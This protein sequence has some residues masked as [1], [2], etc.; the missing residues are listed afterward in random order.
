M[1]GTSVNPRS[2]QLSRK[3]PWR[4]IALAG[5]ALMALAGLAPGASGEVSLYN[6]NFESPTILN[7]WTLTGDW[8]FKTNSACLPNELGYISPQTA[9]V[10]DFASECG[11]RNG[12]SGFATTKFDIE[13]PITLPAVRLQW[14]DYVEAEVGADFYF[15]QISTDG[16][17][18]WPFEVFRDSVNENFW[19]LESVD[20]T[21]FIGNSIRVRFGFSSDES[22]TGLGWYIDDLK[23]VGDELDPNVSAVAIEDA[24]VLEG[25]VGTT[26]MSFN[27]DIQP[28][29]ADPIIFER[30]TV[31]GTAIAGLDYVGTAGPV[32]IP[33]NTTSA[34]IVVDVLGDAFFESDETF[35]LNIFNPSDNAVITIGSAT[36]TIQ[37]DEVLTDKYVEDFEGNQ[38]GTF[39]WST[40]FLPD[41][42]PASALPGFP[43]LELWHIQS[44]SACLPG[45]VDGHTSPTR[46]LVFND[47]TNCNYDT[48]GAI[49]G[50][51]F[52]TS[53]QALHP[54]DVL[55]AEV[56]FQH[57]LE[58]TYN[59]GGATPPT[60]SLLIST[61]GN[62]FNP[63]AT[64]G[65]QEASAQN[66]RIPWRK[67][68]VDL[69]PYIGSSIQLAF[70]FTSPAQGA[71]ISGA[72]WYID[73]F[74]ISVS[75]RPAPVSKV[76]VQDAAVMEGNTGSTTLSFPVLVQ[77][78]NAQD[79]VLSF[80]TLGLTIANAATPDQDY[81][82]TA[83]TVTIPAN[84]GSGVLNV[85]VIGDDEPEAPE[86]YFGLT[87]Q[88][89]SSNVFL[90]REEARGTIQD[91]D[92]PSTFTIK[93]E[94][95][96]TPPPN[97][98]MNESAGALTVEVILS[99]Q[100]SVPIEVKYTTVDQTAVAG[101]GLD[102]LPASG[103]LLF[104]ANTTKRTFTL[105][106][107]EDNQY[108]DPDDIT[109]GKQN[110]TF[111][112]Q[113]TTKSPF[114]QGGSQVFEIVD[115]DAVTLGA[116]NLKIEN[117]T[118]GEG[119]CPTISA[120]D[121]CDTLKQAIFNVTLDPPNSGEITI[122]YTTAEGEALENTDYV[123]T[124]GT[125]TFPAGVVSRS[126]AVDIWADRAIEG[127]ETF[128]LVLSNPTGNVNV[129]Q[130]TGVCTI[131]DDDFVGRAFGMNGAD[132]IQRDLTDPV[133]LPGKTIAGGPVDFDA[134]DFKGFNFDRLYG[135]ANN[136]L[137]EI[138]L[139]RNL[140]LNTTNLAAAAGANTFT[141]VAW[142]HTNGRAIYTLD[143]GDV[144]TSDLAGG[145]FSVAA[146]TGLSILAVAMHPTTGRAYFISRAA[147]IVSLYELTLGSAAPR[148]VGD[149]IIPGGAAVVPG[150]ASQ[151]AKWDLDFDDKTV[152]LYLNAYL[153]G[154]PDFWATFTVDIAE[155]V[156]MQVLTGPAV[157][158]IA[159]ATTP[160]PGGSIWTG[161][162]TYD[163]TSPSG[164]DF[165]ADPATLAGAGAGMVVTGL[166]DVNEDT[167]EDFLI[168]LQASTVGANA[169]AGR[170]FL[171]YGS[172]EGN[173]SDI[174]DQFKNAQAVFDES[175]LD[176]TNGVLIEGNAANLRLGVSASGLGDVNG[177]LVS[178]FAIGYVGANGR[179][180]AYL[181]YGSRNLPTLINVGDVGDPSQ[182]ASVNGLWIKGTSD[183][184]G[185]GS[186][187]SAI[188]DINGDRLGDFIIGVPNALKTGAGRPGKAHIVFGSD[189]GIG[190]N[191]ILNLGALAS[192]NGLTLIGET[193]GDGFG[194]DVS[195]AGDINGDG[196]V[197][198]IVGAPNA[199]GGNGRAYVVYGHID[200]GYDD[201]VVSVL[202]LSRL[203]LFG[204]Q[205][206]RFT[207]VLPGS[208]E[209]AELL[210]PA[211]GN[212]TFEP[213]EIPGALFT[214]QGGGFGSSVAGLGDFSGDGFDDVAIAAPAYDGSA[215]AEAH[216]G[217]IYV[218][219]GDL[220]LDDGV[221][222]GNVGGTVPGLLITGIENG[223]NIGA[224]MAGAG[225]VNGDGLLDLLLGAE[226]ASPQGFSGEAFLVYGS[227]TLAG[228][229]SL[230]DL[231]SPN[232][233]DA[234]GRY[235]IST[236]SSA[237]HDFGMAVSAAGDW[238]NDAII[239]YVVGR[240]DGALLVFGEAEGDTAVFMNRMRTGV[241]D[242]STLP[243]TEPGGIDLSDYVTRPVGHTG[244]GSF[245]TPASGVTITFR[246]GGFGNQLKQASTQ[247][248]TTFRKP[249][250]DIVVNL[251]D[252][253]AQTADEDS[254]W[255]PG[256][257]YWKL[258]TNRNQ[259]TESSIEFHYRPED[260]AGL[261]TQKLGI[262]Y[263]KPTS[264]PSTSTVWS[265][266]PFTVDP[267]RR[268]IT[269][270]RSHASLAQ[271]EFDGYYALIQADLLTFL[272]GVIPA[273]GVTNDTVF[274]GGPDVTP[275]N[276]AFWHEE[277]KKLYAIAPG[278]LNIAW[279]NT[280][281]EI[282]S[283][284]QAV[285]EWPSEGS[286]RYQP[287]VA[288]APPVALQNTGGS[289]EFQSI[290]LTAKDS[291]VVANTDFATTSLANDVTTNR[292]FA[293]AL[294]PNSDPTDLN[295]ADVPTLTGRA[296]LMLSDSPNN[297]QG[298]LF[299]QFVKVVKWNNPAVATG[300]VTGIN[301]P[302]GK[303]IDAQNDPANYG[304]FH[305][306]RAGSPYILFDNAPYAQETDRYVGFYNRALRT[307]S[308]VPVNKKMTGQSDLALLFYQL[309]SRLIEARTGNFIQS[310]NNTGVLNVFSWPHRSN[311][312]IPVWS[313]P[314]S[315][316]ITISRQN[317]SGEIDV[318][319]F[320]VF[321][322]IYYQNDSTKTGYNPNEEH[323]L[324]AP[325]GAGRAV[326]A[327]RNDLND[328]STSE[329]YTLMT[330][331]DPNDLTVD[332]IARAKMRAFKVQASTSDYP[333]GPSPVLPF[334]QDPYEGSAAAFINAPYPLSTLGYSKKNDFISGPVWEDR[335]ERHWA[336]AAGDIVM[337]FYYRP[338]PGFYFPPSYTGRYPF[339]NFDLDSGS[340][341]N[342]VPWLDGGPG[343]VT[344]T[345]E[346][347]YG[348]ADPINVTY[349][350]IWP[351]DVPTMNIGEILIEAKFG[352]PQINGQCSVDLIYQQ[353]VTDP[354][355]GVTAGP[356]AQLV[357]P[358][359]ARSISLDD[360]VF[361]NIDIKKEIRNGETVF[362]DLPPSL[363][364]RLSYDA[365]A[366]R[367]IYRGLLIDPVTGFD[368]AL[369]N[370]L[371]AQDV[372]DVKTLVAPGATGKADWDAAIDLLVADSSTTPGGGDA[373]EIY[374]I[375]DS[376][377]TPFDVLALSTGN[378][379]GTGYVT[380]AFQNADACDPLPVSLEVIEVVANVEP[381][382]IAVVKPPC[383]FDEKLTL[384]QTIQ[385]DGKP[386]D[387]DF[388]WKY[389]P[390]EDGTL[391]DRP[392]PSDPTDPWRDPPINEP[393]SGV[394]INQVIIKGPGLL[395]LTDNW[396][397]VRYKSVDANSPVFGIWSDWTPVQLA[398]G[399][400]KRV[401]GA[402]N[403]FTQ[404]ASGGGIAGAEESFATFG[405][406]APNTIVSMISQ[407]GPRFTGSIPLNCD[408]L[409]AFGLIPIYE[410]VL[411][412]GA[413]LSI[414]SLSPIDNPQVNT[415]L[416]LAASRISDLYML[417]GN[418][419]Y[420]DAQDPTIG[421]GTDD[422][423][424]GQEAT[425]IHA[426]MNQTANLLEEE[427]GLLRGR[428]LSY[429]P[430]I[431]TFPFY[432]RL[433]WNFT[434]DITGGE[435]A[436][437]LNY[438]IRESADGG[439]GIIS[440]AD[441][442]DLYPQGHGDAW[443]HYLTATKTYYDLMRHPFYSWATRSEAVLVGGVP[444]T[445]D[446]YDERRFA[447]AVGQK[448]QAGA[449]LVNLSYRQ[450]YVEDPNGQWQG[451]KDDDTDRRWGF[452]EWASR[453]GQ[454]SY[455]D[456][457]VGNAVLRAVDP[458][459]NH[460]G[461]T[462]IDRTT[463]AE[464]KGIP[465]T[466]LT[467][468]SQ[469]DQADEGLNPLGL[470]TDSVA[471]DISPSQIDDGFTHFEQIYAR[472]VDSLNNA[473]TVFDFANNSTQ[474]LRSQ[475]DS[476]Q[477][478][479]RAVL[480]TER[481]FNSRLI[482]L[483]GRPYDE[484]LGGDGLYDKDYQ[485]ADLYHYMYSEP[486]G[487][488]LD[489]LIDSIY[490]T[491]NYSN[492][493]GNPFDSLDDIGTVE[494]A[495]TKYNGAAPGSGTGDTTTQLA[496]GEGDYSFKVGVRDYGVVDFNIAPGDQILP[497]DAVEVTYNFRNTGGR[498]GLAKPSA[499]T[500][501]RRVPGE[502]QI[503]QAELIQTLGLMMIAVDDYGSFVGK[504]EDM[505]SEIEA[506]YGIKAAQLKLMEDRLDDKKDVQDLIFGLKTGQLIAKTALNIAADVIKNIKDS[507]PTVTGIIVGFSNGVIIDALAPA[508]GAIGTAGAVAEELL[509]GLIDAVDLVVLKKEQAGDRA[510]DRLNI[511]ITELGDNFENL[512]AL[513]ALQ[514]ELRNEIPF[515]VS[516]HNAAEAVKQSSQN[517]LK[518]LA[519]AQRLVDSLEIFRNQTS[520]DVQ[521][522][523]YKDMAFRIFRNEAL[524]KYR[525]QFDLAASYT[526]MAAKAYD[527][528]TVMLSNDPM[529]GQDFLA[530]IVKARQIGKLSGDEPVTGVG[531]ANT[532]AVMARNF[533]VLSGQLGFNNPQVETNRFSLRHELFRV[534]PGAT[535]D[536]DWRQVL[537]QDY[538]ENGEAGRVDNLLDVPEF[539]E[540]CVPPAEWSNT[541]PGVVISFNSTI[542][543]GLNFFGREI[544]SL[545]SSY[546]STQF[547]TK[548]RSV[549][550]WFSNY[551]Y[552]SLSN[553]PRVWLVPAGGDVLRSPTGYR[554][555]QREFN[556]VDLVLPVPFP[557][558]TDELDDPSWIPSVDALAGQFK[559]IRRFGRFRA[560]HDSGEFTP[561]EMIRDS[562]LVGRSVWN[563]RWMLFI[564]G[565][566]FANDREEGLET[567]INGRKTGQ[568][569]D[570]N[571]VEDRDGNGISDIKLFFETYA[572]PRLKKSLEAGLKNADDSNVQVSEVTLVN[573]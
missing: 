484:D 181:I 263:A 354:P 270:D 174:L 259:F 414:N 358:V 323:A 215:A 172:P 166:G 207:D 532:L 179:G 156:A 28:P 225:D 60:A 206:L 386:G 512:Q 146:N 455:I 534:P 271:Q 428:D 418:E 410:T 560:Y 236:N 167:F 55:T 278:V 256:G 478:F 443:G 87:V 427:L 196:L 189:F 202:D 474:L 223:D 269:V 322:D 94:G 388:E 543:E 201:S 273:V 501:E 539:R 161:D 151:D 367:L 59:N 138:D 200:Y 518:T 30:A 324:I 97:P 562:R 447:K 298:N 50:F 231:S 405:L 113:L 80:Q 63:I 342:D 400:I 185:A 333:F 513:L 100:R 313:T 203:A 345:A 473:E 486:A 188:G 440:E 290:T 449:E 31:N 274:P 375:A 239:D 122:A 540:F 126:V 262:F 508:R 158:S 419:A 390:D 305:D 453:A 432:N 143:N 1:I 240:E 72:G 281:N 416:L 197:D 533:E 343:T 503:A 9:L 393:T 491:G 364:F 47:E 213:G 144:L 234:L 571:G 49:D 430:P 436:Y 458:N 204:A 387:F 68:T 331:Y 320:G 241:D 182:G 439:D 398:E 391:P 312:Y 481:D 36:G 291:V 308:I 120:P 222:A 24:T 434:R 302:I 260:V 538:F 376:R 22:F 396:F 377:T 415:A 409:D 404:R 318:A 411:N 163:D 469:V 57:Y 300:A 289:I 528:D 448:A 283:Q 316:T 558:G 450:A 356:S 237:T 280:T 441:A 83:N 514:D 526:Y 485:G 214:G 306:E 25:D 493:T 77:P 365:F 70:R 58:M 506:Q 112:I 171:F 183:N 76:T 346:D 67:E 530:D 82:S 121:P 429:G 303:I 277:D 51:V 69:S 329:P 105:T 555:V 128:Q 139:G 127:N 467:L 426:F 125:I 186:A 317:G 413:D 472:A 347:P 258:D 244:D 470:T 178:D 561:D 287:Y 326:F 218:V 251:D 442:K 309:G 496:I 116:S 117:I 147:N 417:L 420:A 444:V 64:F 170:A 74:R 304:A 190:A 176:G 311:Q 91:D 238:N 465:S 96:I 180:G 451:Y 173:I 268:V 464:L 6:D 480:D 106:I 21:P 301:W 293:G 99:E 335:N 509:R 360:T 545:D 446:Y 42:P 232:T 510:D 93:L 168:T 33:A 369:L 284:V 216:F 175:T 104:P 162:L 288:G 407:A 157:S 567:F 279:K 519:E 148:K 20:L 457:V 408:D 133:A 198:L 507:I 102:Y 500:S 524:Q 123:P 130:N 140:V 193:N 516:L 247:T 314:A 378:A 65:P 340:A 11:Y 19:D 245:S 32:S 103:T 490:F 52:M 66:F 165:Q 497:G 243:G 129:K 536:D 255:I 374:T 194:S 12:R 337:E 370:V 155:A 39:R 266:M 395:T 220:G 81:A 149:L 211:L 294:T 352:L 142:D 84:T 107:L 499:W 328:A 229:L 315:D 224:S 321:Q 62:N 476:I 412:R 521:Q 397:A 75:E 195:C 349:R 550:V 459:P 131:V 111:A 285:N 341:V 511:N 549:G 433:I 209:L 110:E 227:N 13:I 477:A 435:V 212:V 8:R 286:G 249:S 348:S 26:S 160:P 445:V 363:N 169:N 205:G 566:T 565:S 135:V 2:N 217:R 124:S 431:D 339:L 402:I 483:F 548:I 248:V 380:L 504:V 53:P 462:K 276:L 118:V 351:D 89:V 250:P 475:N 368:Y 264:A 267:D 505:V 141:G 438:N 14:M 461:L 373:G 535:S 150:S 357:D 330:Y 98:Q 86:E 547:A 334:A 454:G 424:Y 522:Q 362:T 573:E 34:T 242:L 191:G 15:V 381:G 385:F 208:S 495:I 327:L 489:G 154:T 332:G 192:P 523:R 371:T 564:A 282:V 85:L 246:G 456:W 254:R 468:Q 361:L 226:G 199:N 132:V 525:A 41:T 556:V 559:Q 48:G 384:T 531:L 109:A 471:F 221:A 114:A 54:V 228:T 43:D 177:D 18:T 355:S 275:S 319:T 79:V 23:I 7:S 466:Y 136:F 336:K 344:G 423:V 572:Y 338:Q 61:D 27:V 257:V 252:N 29:N 372:L 569:L 235:I 153:S 17:V 40:G 554:G 403:P 437:A 134:V 159:I 392:D 421:F 230:R 297:K 5:I 35:T 382:A 383:V 557:L 299:F 394:G 422:G 553:T 515:R 101:A 16:G 452:G 95:G 187:I 295:G 552:L 78:P 460:A 546:D 488:F 350:T 517:Y 479:Q 233:A 399:W 38:Q 73:D 307:G 92:T 108:E 389:L 551:D 119:S 541:E 492:P 494:E 463:V 184:D 88:N 37:D 537:N 570:G 379:K 3:R 520:A 137:Y 219:Y 563:R 353:S 46:S 152:M 261:N 44:A 292:Q 542:K 529:A 56:S 482:E 527:Y 210:N 10:F 145:A 425:S 544:G 90:V 71:P 502:L 45:G 296:L 310:A 164:I 115:N 4:Q 265:W 325:Y 253:P 359:I 498:F 487:I 366:E 406:D 568:D 401:V 272:G